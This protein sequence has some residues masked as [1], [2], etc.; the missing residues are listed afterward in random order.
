MLM[1]TDFGCSSH[2]LCHLKFFGFEAK[3]MQDVLANLLADGEDRTYI[4]VHGHNHCLR[5][6]TV[7]PNTMTDLI[8]E[9]E[10]DWQTGR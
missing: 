7:I 9:Q 10:S 6:E 8:N 5:V 2:K 1:V 4:C 3:M